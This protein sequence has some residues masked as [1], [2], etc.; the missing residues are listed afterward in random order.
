VTD[1]RGFTTLA[2]A[3][4]S[5]VIAGVTIALAA[6]ETLPF[7]KD[8]PLAVVAGLLA[9]LSVLPRRLSARRVVAAFVVGLAVGFA[10]YLGATL[11]TLTWWEA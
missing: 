4:A 11:A 7:W 9:G 8:R 5:L 10:T 1:A 6:A 2:L 3:A